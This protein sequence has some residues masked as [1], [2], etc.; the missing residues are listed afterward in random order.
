MFSHLTGVRRILATSYFIT[1]VPMAIGVALPLPSH[2]GFFKN[3]LLTMQSLNL[4]AL[5]AP[6]EANHF[7]KSKFSGEDRVVTDETHAAFA[8]QQAVQANE[9]AALVVGGHD[10]PKKRF[11]I[12]SVGKQEKPEFLALTTVIWPT[13]GGRPSENAEFV[14][15]ANKKK[16][17]V[18]D[19]T[20]I[21]WRADFFKFLGIKGSDTVSVGSQIDAAM[22]RFHH[23]LGDGEISGIWIENTPSSKG[24]L[25]PT[26]IV[27]NGQGIMMW[28]HVVSYYDTKLFLGS[29]FDALID[30]HKSG[31]V[32]EFARAAYFYYNG[33][34]FKRGSAAIGNAWLAGEFLGKTGV[35]LPFVDGVDRFAMTMTQEQ[36]VEFYT[37]QISAKFR[38][39]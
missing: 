35:H 14:E 22:H 13:R 4:S 38:G 6:Y 29:A 20:N 15:L 9:I 12:F 18:P 37:D 16:F 7:P 34:P 24:N 19:Q 32:Q 1:L 27:K 36:F 25:F 23:Q 28:S 11:A 8:I 2:A 39:E 30:F 10:S 3:C 21:K 5:T 31:S 17:Y 26:M 33:I